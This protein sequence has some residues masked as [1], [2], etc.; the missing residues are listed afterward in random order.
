[1]SRAGAA[2]PAPP[3]AL[4]GPGGTQLGWASAAAPDRASTQ[5]AIIG[6]LSMKVSFRGCWSA[7]A[8]CGGD[9]ASVAVLPQLDP[10]RGAFANRTGDRQWPKN[11]RPAG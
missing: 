11:Q 5:A 8:A 2:P 1:M 9:V 3:G 4:F 7:N 6:I 10:G